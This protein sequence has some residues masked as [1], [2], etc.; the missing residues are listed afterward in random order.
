MMTKYKWWLAAGVFALTVTWTLEARAKGPDSS[1]VAPPRGMPACSTD[2]LIKAYIPRDWIKSPPHPT[3]VRLKGDGW[4]GRYKHGS[5]RLW[6]QVF[7]TFNRGARK[8][9]L[10]KAHGVGR[11]TGKTRN[12][13]FVTKTARPKSGDLWEMAKWDNW[14][15][16]R[17]WVHAQ[18]SV[19]LPLIRTAPAIDYK[20]D[21][22]LRPVD[23]CRRIA[24][25]I[26]GTIDGFPGYAIYIG[27]KMVYHFDPYKVGNGPTALYPYRGDVRLKQTGSVRVRR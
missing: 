27:N 26:T 21:V 14:R 15:R 22:K 12:G 23:N 13:G 17:V 11:S 7:V 9:E 10:R 4:A 20:V 3:Y 18:G 19:G 25:T 1:G 24:Y 5:A 2:V 8:P 16:T 6:N